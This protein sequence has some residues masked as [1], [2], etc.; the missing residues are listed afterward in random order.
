MYCKKIQAAI[1][2]LLITTATGVAQTVPGPNGEPVT[3]LNSNRVITTAVPFL[4]IN[5]ESRAGGMGD[6]GVATSPNAASLYW[7]PG[8][9]AFIEDDFGFSLSYSPWLRRLVGDMSISYVSGYYKRRKEELIGVSLTYFDYGSI[10][11]TDINGNVTNQVHPR[12]FAPQVN[13]SRKLSDKLGLGLGIKMI[14]SNLNT[15]TQGDNKAT[16]SAAADL[17]IYYNTPVKIKLTKNNLALGLAITN[18]GGKINYVSNDTR[19]F[20]PTNLR[21]GAAFTHEL[22]LYNKI[23]ITAEASKLLVPTP[24]LYGRDSAT[25]KTVIVDGKDTKDMGVV[26]GM[27]NSFSDAGSFKG[28]MQEILYGIGAEYWY[29]NIF[30][31]RAGYHYENPNKGNRKYFTVGVGIKYQTFMLDMAYIISSKQQNPLGETL[32]FTLGMNFKKKA[33]G[34]DDSIQSE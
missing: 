16:L 26:T 23:T 25:G 34:G 19:S 9:A 20:I 13:Y 6:V 29:N 31:I 18:I 24:P 12:E 21:L 32:R 8:K 10:N 14:Y 33:K 7:N 22:D 1:L 17:G 2:L 15:G 4:N 30:A 28:E 3:L 11:F 5:P 27:V